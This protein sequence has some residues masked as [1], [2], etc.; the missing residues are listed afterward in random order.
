MKRILLA[1]SGS[2]AFYKAYELISMF[3]KDGISVKVLLSNGAL[4]FATPLGFEALCEGVLHEGN[5]S[6][7]NERNHIA[8]SKDCDAVVFAPASANSICKLSLGCA[9]SLF[10]QSLLALNPAKPFLIAPAANTNMITHF[11]VKEAL[12][13]LQANGAVIIPPVCKTLACKDEGLGGLADIKDIFLAT[14]KEL[15]K[16]TFWENKSVLITGGGTKEKI[17]EVR[18]ISNFSS[19]KMAKAVA[20]AFYLAGAKVTLLSS[21]PTPHAPYPVKAFKS[22]SELDALMDEYK[23]LDYL[24]M[25]AAVSDFIPKNQASGK[26]KKADFK[27]DFKIELSLNK[28][29]LKNTSFKGKKIGFK[30]EFDKENAK[31]C[32]TNMLH[33]KKLDLVCL[34]ILD[35]NMSFGSSSNELIFI[36]KDSQSEPSGVKSK[37]ELARSLVKRCESL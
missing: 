30:M 36:D 27:D 12:E 24:I 8:F 15:F 18:C 10:I 35:K 31:K 32:A 29:L 25:L 6:W 20:D 1:I 33:E 22:S 16:R 14:K 11:S 9:D 37:V 19:G 13:K 21:A 17:D 2:I 3:K 7:E 34:N 28:D 4:R 23:D 26:L 5:E